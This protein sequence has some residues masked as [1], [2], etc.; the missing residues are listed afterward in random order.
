MTVARTL[1]NWNRAMIGAYNKGKTAR[2]TG[3]PIS[4]NPYG[5]KRKP[6]GRLTWSRA[7]YKCW[8]DG[9]RDAEKEGKDDER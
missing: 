7:F 2:K 8:E 1:K 4:E 3:I 6:D 5:D 9:W